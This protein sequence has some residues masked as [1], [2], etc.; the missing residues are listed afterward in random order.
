MKQ[1][2]SDAQLCAWTN[3]SQDRGARE[4]SV[5]TSPISHKVNAQMYEERLQLNNNKN[6]TFP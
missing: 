2:V 4:G 5:V 3:G 6:I 1:S